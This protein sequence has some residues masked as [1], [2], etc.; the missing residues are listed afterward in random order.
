M[1]DDKIKN[2]SLETIILTIVMSILIT[3]IIYYFSILL[4]FLPI[5]FI[6]FGIK[7]DI[8]SSIISMVSSLLLVG[9]ILDPMIALVSILIF[10][11]FT[12]ANIYLIKKRTKP[13]R[14]VAY[15][16][17][18]FFASLIV[19]YAILGVG[20]FNL[21]SQLQE[22]FNQAL[23]LQMDVFEEMGLTSYERLERRDL[24]QTAYNT[25][26]M[27]IPAIMFMSSLLISYSSYLLTTFGLR[28]L[29]INIINMP[30]FSRF[31]LPENFSMG[32]LIM[33]VTTFILSIMEV[34]QGD[35]IYLN[36]MY[37]LQFLLFI[38]GM[39]VVSHF[40]I[41][42]KMRKFFRIITIL[43]IILT[44]QLFQIISIIGVVDVIFDLRK[45]KKAKPL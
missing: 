33:V 8:I 39:A 3:G 25:F 45:I 17:A 30:R 14:V 19:L 20:G 41:R 27:M 43:I 40:L 11:P 7:N 31:R 22:I 37:I 29:G 38:Q 32:A 10:G 21:V 15:G 1:N 13:Y 42:I 34:E 12:I 9:I 2:K 6:I 28:R 18:I 5:P 35:S 23:S 44:P 16:A 26:F 36:I 24:I 4:V